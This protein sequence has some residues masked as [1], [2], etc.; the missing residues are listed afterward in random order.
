MNK[1]FMMIKTDSTA[2][3]L[4]CH[5]ETGVWQIYDFISWIEHKPP[6]VQ[7]QD[8]MGWMEKN[9]A[10]F[11]SGYA[12]DHDQNSVSFSE[13]DLLEFTELIDELDL[14]K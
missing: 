7:G 3:M 10:E 5:P 14:R 2:W 9:G 6:F 13:S 4:H 1:T 8:V 12:W 11:H